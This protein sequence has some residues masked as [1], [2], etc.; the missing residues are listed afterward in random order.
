MIYSSKIVQDIREIRELLKTDIMKA[1]IKAVIFDADGPLYYRTAEI[2]QKKQS[3]LAEFGYH[4]DMQCFENAYEKEKFKGYAGVEAAEEMFQ[5]ILRAIGLGVSSE[6]VA[7]FT[8]E[9]DAIHRQVTA[10]TDAIATLRRLKDEG[11]KICI[12]TD[13]FYSAE[14]KWLWFKELG[15]DGYLDRI[16]SSYN[17]QKLKDTPEA[18]DACLEALGVSAGEVVFVGHQEYEMTGALA[19][20]IISIA[21]MPIATTGIHADYKVH[22][23]S[24]LPDLLKEINRSN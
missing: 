11:Y 19:S 24:E 10:T 7:V 20:K 21:V 13:S 23:L 17:I 16:V 6:E 4:G 15:M 5:N 18:Y 3:L 2:T 22:S 8:K 12:L 9:I 14:E 1:M